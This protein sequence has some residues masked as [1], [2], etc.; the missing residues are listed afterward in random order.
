LPQV[1]NA[2]PVVFKLTERDDGFGSREI[3]VG[4][5]LDRAVV[6]ELATALDR[7]VALGLDISL[8]FAE[9]TFIDGGVVEALVRCDEKLASQGRQILLCGTAGQVR[10]MLWA[11]GLAGSNHGP[12]LPL[13]RPS[14]GL[15]PAIAG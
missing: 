3:A 4:G 12:A 14:R 8:N 9:C 10:R 11:T 13:A 1:R 7:A 15:A 5:E 2:V 6:G